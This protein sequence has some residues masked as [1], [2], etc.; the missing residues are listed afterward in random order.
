[1]A[2][3]V[4]TALVFSLA[5][6]YFHDAAQARMLWGRDRFAM[7][8]LKVS[9]PDYKVEYN[10]FPIPE[11]S[12]TDRDLAL[13]SRGPMLSAL[14]GKEA[15]G[16]NRKKI[17]LIILPMAKNRQ[18]GLWQDGEEWVLSDQWGEPFH[19]ILDTNGDD[20]IANPEYGAD[21]SDPSYARQCKVSPPP[22]EIPAATII[23]SS[24]PDRNP[25][26]WHDNICSWRDLPIPIPH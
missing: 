23:Y 25:K 22:P 9:I 2:I 14:L 13:R 10:H 3:I 17:K 26:T 5:L 6:Y 21:Q 18:S 4:I 1:M 7:K 19:I 15:G 16:L 20:M 11:D 8:D 12:P 24:G